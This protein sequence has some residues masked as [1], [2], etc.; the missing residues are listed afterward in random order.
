MGCRDKRMCP[1]E[2]GIEIDC[3]LR[4][5]TCLGDIVRRPAPKSLRPE[6]LIVVRGQVARPLD[7]G[8]FA[9]GF[10]QP[11]RQGG[12]DGLGHLV[13]NSENVLEITI[14]ALRPQVPAGEPIELRLQGEDLE[15][16]RRAAVDT[17]RWLERIDGVF[18]LSMTPSQVAGTDLLLIPTDTMR[19]FYDHFLQHGE[20][21]RDPDISPLWADLSGLPP[22]LLSVGT[23]DP[24]LDDSLFM[25]SRLRAAGNTATLDVYPQA[26][27]GFTVLPGPA[28]EVANRRANEFIASCWS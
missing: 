12:Y 19:W 24:L 15:T 11:T 21:R 25:A 8:L 3:S 27:H 17:Q 16:L 23:S 9:R 18:D 6:Q 2:T 20:D 22:S 5:P 10:F 28:G 14:I 7:L 1:G 13:L 26:I 4:Q